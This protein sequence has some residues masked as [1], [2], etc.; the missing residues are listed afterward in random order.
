MRA[1]RKL[2]ASVERG[3][4]Q[5]G[6]HRQD[7]VLHLTVLCHQ[8]GERALRLQPHEFDV[9]EPH[10][11]LGGEH[12]AG[13]AGQPRQCL[14]GFGEDRF[15]RL[16]LPGARHLRF[17]I[18]PVVFGEVAHF[19]QRVDEEAQAELGRQPP[20]RG[21]RRIDQPELL[22]VRHHVAHRGRRQ[23]D[24]QDARQVA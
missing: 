19:H 15:Q 24:R 13:R 18:V 22:Q 16:G 23:R 9:L 3:G 20:G 10:I 14:R 11:A 6:R 4:R 12:D 21:V 17:D 1:L 7:A 5:P 8:H 2:A